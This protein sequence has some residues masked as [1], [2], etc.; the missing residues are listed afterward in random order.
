MSPAAHGL[1]LNLGSRDGGIKGSTGGRG[2]RVR[3]AIP[4]EE[5]SVRAFGRLFAGAPS[6]KPLGGLTLAEDRCGG[7]GVGGEPVQVF[8]RERLG[9]AAGGVDHADGSAAVE[10]GDGQ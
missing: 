8:F 9:R 2:G 10:D 6:S 5:E 7:A 1:G 3:L 4:W